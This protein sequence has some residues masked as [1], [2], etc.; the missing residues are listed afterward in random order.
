MATSGKRLAALFLVTL[1]L[2]GQTEAEKLRRLF[3]AGERAV[4]ADSPESVVVQRGWPEGPGR[5]NDRSFEGYAR[6][7][8]FNKEQLS[9]VEAIRPESLS[10]ADRLNHALYRHRLQA[11]VGMSRFPSELLTLTNRYQSPAVYM[12]RLLQTVPARNAAEYGKLLDLLRGIAPRL[13]QQQALLERGIETGVVQPSVAVRAVPGQ[14]DKLAAA[15]PAT[16]PLLEQF[17]KFPSSIPAGEQQR[18]LREAAAILDGEVA[19]A[20]RKFG[21][22]V[23]EKYL[24]RARNDIARSS[25][26]Y[27]KAWYAAEVRQETSTDLT[28]E[29]IHE[30]GLAEVKRIRAEM[31]AAIRR[32]GFQGS[33]RE[34]QEFLR[35]DPRFYFTK[36]DDLLTAYRALCKEIDPQ[37]P[38]LFGRLPRTPYGVRPFPEVAA[39]T[40]TS[41]QYDRPGVS[42]PGWVSVNTYRL[43]HR[44]KYEMEALALHEGVPGHHLQL[45]LQ[46][47]MPA[48]PRFRR[49]MRVNAFSEGWGLY[50]ESLGEELGFYRDPYSKFGQLSMEI[51]R[52]CR[53]V[54]DT[55]MHAFG[56]TRQ[57]AID[58]MKEH[59]A[60]TGQNIVAEIDRY[61][62]TPA[63]ALSYKIGELKFKELRKLAETELGPRFDIRKFHD[64]VLANG[65]LPLTILQAQVRK[66][67][68]EEKK[69]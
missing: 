18:L 13:A 8:A 68:Q 34:F 30:I 52:A 1:P 64:A 56:W 45:A 27:G 7:R 16:S 28:P 37:L 15:P 2:Y 46:V 32:A 31:D 36:P 25:L 55:G 59:T 5:W 44:P 58:Y 51:L 60:L 3:E 40:A 50:A 17:R 47:E 61:I 33:F 63:Q 57:R 65:S 26:P 54:V 38:K 42:R 23:S 53:L 48:A 19:P 12:P 66:F 69:K 11:V 43:D 41:A 4:E 20:L 22:F 24:P 6:L 14:L 39:P 62:D 21:A 67:I 49:R 29:Q 9:A 35:T 10:P